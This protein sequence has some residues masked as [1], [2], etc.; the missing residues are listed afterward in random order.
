[1]NDENLPC[2]NHMSTFGNHQSS[3][4]AIDRFGENI[5]QLKNNNGTRTGWAVE[6][7]REREIINGLGE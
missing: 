7:E 2:K 4:L 5:G 1:M 6:R 3:L